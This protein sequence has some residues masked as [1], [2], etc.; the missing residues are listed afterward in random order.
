MNEFRKKR[1]SAAAH[2]SKT[3]SWSFCI[4]RNSGELRKMILERIH[5]L[6]LSYAQVSMYLGID[7]GRFMR[8]L[9]TYRMVRGVMTQIE[10]IR[11]CKLLGID[12]RLQIVKKDLSS[13]KDVMI[14]KIKA[15]LKEELTNKERMLIFNKASHEVLKVRVA[16]EL[17]KL[18][19]RKE[20]GDLFKGMYEM[21]VEGL[22]VEIKRREGKIGKLE[23]KVQEEREMR[24]KIIYEANKYK[25][26]QVKSY[27]KEIRYYK[28]MAKYFYKENHKFKKL[29]KQGRKK[30]GVYYF[31]SLKILS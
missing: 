10:V 27:V 7:H 1:I 12:L 5:Y 8:Y 30:W 26:R 9:G 18:Q 22:K 31:P 14:S 11:V 17:Y 24:S 29:W 28:A 20:I 2:R 4:I 13:V 19:Y 6:G 15:Y 23:S 16:P 3:L 25:R 21:K